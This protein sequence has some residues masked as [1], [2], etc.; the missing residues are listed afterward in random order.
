MATAAPRIALFTL[1][2]L[3]NARAVR[4]FVVNHA[5]EIV[6]T[7]LSNPFRKNAG[8]LFGQTARHFRRS[9]MRFMPYLAA[10]FTL[11]RISA[12]FGSSA[13]K[14]EEMPLARLCAQRGIRSA[15]IDDVNGPECHALLAET[16]PDLI[17]SFHF[18]Q[19]FSARTLALAPQGGINLHP[20]L[21]PHHRGPVPTLHA[22]MEEPPL[23]G[24]TIHRLATQIDS[25]AILAQ[26]RVELATGTTASRAMRSLHERGRRLLDHVLEDMR[27][28][29]VTEQYV[30]PLPY[31]PFPSREML[32]AMRK[33][34][35][36]AC[37]LADLRA[38]LRLKII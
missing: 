4:R 12:L 28:D 23:F 6:L 32:G 36:T 18:D 26:A 3:A 24:V 35:L 22:L 30:E 25:G 21:L 10:N 37:D 1:E 7:G 38:G 8:G 20:S 31:C 13:Q 29:R 19:I 27:H 15:V 33:R 9:G 16:R 17:I 34:G 2:S 11:P 5:G 14:D